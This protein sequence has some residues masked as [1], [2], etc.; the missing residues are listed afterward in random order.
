MFTILLTPKTTTSALEVPR[1]T[2]A[3]LNN[4]K[5]LQSGKVPFILTE[6][7]ENWESRSKF[8][9]LNW[10]AETFPD[11]IVDYYPENLATVD[12]KPFLRPMSGVLKEFSI[13]NPMPSG[14]W[15][16]NGRSEKARYIHWR[17]TAS[18]W[19]KVKNLLT[20]MNSFFTTDKLWM[21]QCIPKK[22]RNPKNKRQVN[23][24]LNNWIKHAHWKIIVI[25]EEDS[26]M[27]FHADGFSTSTFVF[28]FLG[29]KRWTLC[30][31][32]L[33]MRNME[34]AGVIDTFGTQ[35]HLSQFPKYKKADCA[36]FD[37]HP[38]E[39]IYYPSHFW[40]QTLNLDRPCVS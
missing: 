30:E 22:I 16:Q 19:N 11:A 37:V 3:E 34:N 33:E 17:M 36:Q 35:E 20:P 4:S 23:W 31:P 32:D 27:F 10:F 7:M 9:D 5:L 15:S 25:G 40:H 39:V 21:N 29:R 6:S 2:P 38:G 12:K 28:Q 24:P 13:R 14:G 1:V 26:G 18:Q 8:S